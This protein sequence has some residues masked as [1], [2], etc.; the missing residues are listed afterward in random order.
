M[1]KDYEIN[2]KEIF[3]IIKRYIVFIFLFVFII[4]SISIVYVL[5]KPNI[6]RVS[7]TI[8]KHKM[9]SIVLLKN[10]YIFNYDINKI[11]E[12]FDFDY[13]NLIR[14][15]FFMKNFIQKNGLDKDIAS[16]KVKKDYVFASQG[17]FILE[18]LENLRSKENQK[19]QKIDFFSNIY[20]PFIS[21][22]SISQDK[23][24]EIITITYV[25]P[26]RFF[27]YKVVSS[28]LKDGINYLVNKNVKNLEFQIKK[29]QEEIKTTNNLELKSELANLIFTLL[30]QKAYIKSSK[31]YK[32]KNKPYIPN[33]ED[34]MGPKRKTFI[35]VSFVASL[36][37]AI[38][39]VFI[40]EFIKHIK[41]E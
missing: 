3:I 14:D 1:E 30:K 32:I 19:N 41:E 17:K 23:E 18:F 11:L 15:Q 40:I 13:S 7:A 21:G 26:N 22:F 4:T 6:Y 31:I 34:K 37:V 28:F 36:V 27:A 20:I 10:D 35:I 25:H 38:I 29:Y 39:L 8:I 2:I 33:K 9:P 24:K 12:S 5:S 16:G